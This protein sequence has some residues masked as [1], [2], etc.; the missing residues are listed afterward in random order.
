MV[1]FSLW[2]LHPWLA[3]IGIL[4]S[5]LIALWLLAA[6]PC[7]IWRRREIEAWDW[8]MMTFSVFLIATLLIPDTFFAHS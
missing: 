1:G 4:S 5:L 6:I 8:S 3:A 7:A 2:H